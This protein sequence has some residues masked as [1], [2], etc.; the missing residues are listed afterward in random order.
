MN[1][2][3]HGEL[4]TVRPVSRRASSSGSGSQSDFSQSRSPQ[5]DSVESSSE[6]SLPP[7]K[8]IQPYRRKFNQ[9]S[10]SASS[11]PESQESGEE[12]AEIKHR[13]ERKRQLKNKL[14]LKPKRAKRV[15]SK[16]SASSDVPV[17]GKRIR[18]P[19]LLRQE[20]DETNLMLSSQRQKQL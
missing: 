13:R 19:S 2:F 14:V 10:E 9:R 20:H 6:D 11:D 15:V 18:K 17:L 4:R 3:F 5:E 16:S 8:R 7:V 12:S 1:D